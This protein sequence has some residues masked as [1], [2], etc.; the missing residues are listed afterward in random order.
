[1]SMIR[2]LVTAAVLVTALAACGGDPAP[3][4]SDAGS[5]AAPPVGSS[6][7]PDD[8]AAAGAAGGDEAAVETA[9]SDYNQALAERDFATACALNAPESVEALL[10]G[11]EQGLGQRPAD[12]VAA[13]EIIYAT[14]GAAELADATTTSTEIQD[15]TVTGG[16]ATV[17]WS[18][19]V[20]DQ[21]QTVSSD[22]RRI[23]GDWRLVDTG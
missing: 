20:R 18:A 16:D 3:A 6:A 14:P 21:R 5:T 13:F 2:N 19:Q 10:S 1:M 12:C 22:L 8:P 7:A 17:T 9:F 11:V 23:D 15:V 4:D